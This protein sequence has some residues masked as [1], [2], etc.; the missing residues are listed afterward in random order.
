MQRTIAQ[1]Y[2]YWLL[3]GKGVLKYAEGGMVEG[4]FRD[5]MLEGHAKVGPDWLLYRRLLIQ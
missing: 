1:S 3:Q 5:D 4:Q 2:G